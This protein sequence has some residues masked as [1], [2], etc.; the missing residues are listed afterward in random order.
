MNIKAVAQKAGVSVATVSRVLNH[1]DAVAPDTKEHILNIMES[2]NYTPNWFARGLKL[3]RTGVIALLIPEIIDSGYMEIAKGV[4]D[5]A[6]QKKYNIMLCATEEDR[7]KEKDYIENFIT[8]KVDGIILVSTYLNKNDLLQIKKQDIPVVLIGKN[9]ELT[10]ENLVYTDYKSA[11][12]EA[13]RHMIEVGH[14]KIGMICGSRPKIENMDKLEGFQKTIMEEDLI[15]QPELVVEE[16]NSIEG[17]Y[18]GASKL[19]NLKERP[20]A[21]FITSDIMAIGAMEKIKRTGLKIPQDIAVVGFDNLKISG[22]IEP[23]L[24]TVAKPMYRMGLVAARLLFDLME[25]E[26]D[27]DS[28]PQEILI[29]SKLKV[30]KSCGHQ[31]RVKEIF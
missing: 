13:V 4:E 17:G 20:E 1:P 22:Y 8:R 18:L 27:E 9:E 30:R 21:I 6:H 7:S 12:G 10:G 28:E 31:G 26:S 14:R 16:E 25:D 15:Y 19:L 24:T 23:K 3:N 11:A 2:L 5:I 29:Q